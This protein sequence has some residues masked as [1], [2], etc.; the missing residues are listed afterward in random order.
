MIIPVSG[1]QNLE[2][3]DDSHNYDSDMSDDDDDRL[4]IRNFLKGIQY[5]NK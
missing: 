1:Q 2:S 4:F 5:I 3:D